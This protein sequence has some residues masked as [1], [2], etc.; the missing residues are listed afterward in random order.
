MFIGK[1]IKELREL[2]KMSLT[3]LSKRS[4]VQM[5]TLSRMENLK[6]TGTLASHMNI[7]KALGVSLPDLY[8][9]IVTEE[10]KIEA[11]TS[12]YATDIFT[13][14]EKSAYEIL[15]SKVLA[16]KMMPIL[17]KI[18]SGGKT[19]TE[20]NSLGTEKFLFVLDGKV[21][22]TV[23]KEA[24]VLSKNDTLYFDASL[25]YYIENIGRAPAKIL[26]VSTPVAL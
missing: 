23:E 8:R 9:G 4:G 1:K 19:N 5:A 11:R 18:E 21:S 6:M 26:C 25:P 22:V 15:T 20:Q 16:K 10:K 13:H 3:E 24:Y 7:A 12:R 2:Q 14:S 17:L